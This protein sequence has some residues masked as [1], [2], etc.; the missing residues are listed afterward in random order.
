[1]VEVSKIR[2]IVLSVIDIPGSVITIDDDLQNIGMNSILFIQ[3]V[4]EI[5]NRFDIE[6]PDEKLLITEANTIKKLCEIVTSCVDIDN[7]AD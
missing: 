3:I 7:T 1:M 4:V 6:F 5:E 2:E